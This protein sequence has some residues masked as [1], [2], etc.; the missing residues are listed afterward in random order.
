MSNKLMQNINDKDFNISEYFGKL[1]KIYAIKDKNQTLTETLNEFNQITKSYSDFVQNNSDE[2]TYSDYNFLKCSRE[3]QEQFFNDQL[4]LLECLVTNSIYDKQGLIWNWYDIY[5]LL[6]DASYKNTDKI[7]RKVV[8]STST[9]SRPIGNSSY[10][11]WNGMQIIDLDIKDEMI[12]SNL[13][14]KIFDE[15]KRYHW[16][17]GVCKSASGKGL[18]IW[19]KIT[20]LSFEATN[21]KVEYLCNFRHKYSYVYIVLTKYASQYGYTKDK[22][23]EYMDMAMAKPQ[24]GIFISSDNTA[25]LN[26]NFKDLRLDVNFESAFVSGVESINWISHPDL[27][28]IFHKLEWFNTERET[29]DVDVSNISGIND[30]DAKNSK[31]K[32]HYKHAQRW[33]LANTLTSIYGYDKALSLMVEICKGTSYNELAGDV[34][35]AS[36]HNKPISTWAIKELNRQHG[37][38]LKIKA[39][40]LYKK[41]IEKI[42]EDIKTSPDT[43]PIKILNSNTEHIELH[44][45]SNQ[46]L[47][48]IKSDI[49]KNLSHITLLEAGAGY[50]KTEMIKS[51]KAKTML[52]LPFTSTIKAKVEA[53]S[54]TSDWLYYYGS[55]RPTLDEILGDKN[56]SMTIDKFSNLNIMELDQANFEYIVIDES[57][58]LFTSSYRDVMSPTI[59]RLANCKAKV[60]MMTGTPTGE[61]LFFPSIKH[62]K[63]IKEDFR[64][65]EFNV[66]MVPTKN[67]KMTKMCKMMAKDIIDGKKILYPTNKGN[68]FYSQVTGLIQ[69]YLNIY[70]YPNKLKSFYYK[71]SNYGDESMDNINFSKTVGNNDIVFC[72]NYLSV[73]VDIC[74]RNTFSVYF[75]EPWIAQDIEQFANRLRNNDL[76]VTLILEK[77]DSTGF[78]IDYYHTMPLDLSISQKDL[79]LSRDLIRTCND[80][81][82]R[83]N[84]ESKYNPLIQSLLA[85]NRYLKYDE[86]DCKY[87][88]DETTYKLRV[89]EERYSDYSKQLSVMIDGMKYY[90][91]HTTKSDDNERIPED[92]LEWL[93][94]YMKSCRHIRYDWWTNQ[95]FI[96]LD[97]LND[98]NIDVY[99]ELL[100]GDYALFKDDKYKEERDEH[101]LYVESIEILERNI[102]IILGLYKFYACDTIKEIYEYCI[103]K[104]QNKINYAKLDRIRRFVN[105]ESNRRQ[106]RLDFPVYK[107]IKD[108]QQFAKDNPVIS[109][110]DLT[111][112]LANYAAKYANS[113]KNIVVDDIDFLEEIYDLV[114]QLFNVVVIKGRPSKGMIKISPFE[115]LWEQKNDLTNL[116][117]NLNTKEFFSD[118]I[119]NMVVDE[120]EEELPELEHTS[121]LQLKDIIYELPNV[122]HKQYDYFEYSS[123]DKSNERFMRKQ[124]NT[125]TLRDNIFAQIDNND[126]PKDE[127]KNLQGNLFEKTVFKNI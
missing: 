12:A 15:L 117:G 86:N 2:L 72:S 77:E 100:K 53:D 68:L 30:R 63:V 37:F 13:K 71:K 51:L 126:I 20:P 7:Q 11:I 80:M 59:Q 60:I 52:I 32:L 113:I 64:Q 103:D 4:Q 36:I 47:S 83:N 95:T 45:K 70:K 66:V 92:K 105:I 85:S 27:K 107:Y 108:A 90:G 65:K 50:G 98:G 104:K 101:N 38:N 127:S 109:Q 1:N 40:D 123:L 125:N 57:H 43:D 8:Y 9:N 122:V 31:G 16:F 119:D 49:I 97:H 54:K 88:I 110:E 10:L 111:K 67:E 94:D 23:F 46:Y 22:I 78:P 58:L 121:K 69:E 24:Q 28:D 87:Y 21:R 79:L 120:T 102:P 3:E 74:D 114:C 91:Y 93:G 73:G 61:I 25:L 42:E 26:T 41:E 29:D 112:G 81:L 6:Y 62:I 116:Y 5:K 18:H 34:K 56:M 76:Y 48:D 14:Q 84:E 33:Q 96:L 39:E 89:F 75:S 99:K 106:K 124:E 19:T 82:E 17:L 44:L 115:L 118:L 35:T 55:K